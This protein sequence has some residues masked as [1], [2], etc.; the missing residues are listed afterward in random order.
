ML[1]NIEHRVCFMDIAEKFG[2]RSTAHLLL[3]CIFRHEIRTP[4]E[5]NYFGALANLEDLKELVCVQ[6][7]YVNRNENM[8]IIDHSSVI[9][10]AIIFK[11]IMSIQV[12]T[13]V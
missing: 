7:F 4:G 8:C 5:S 13:P 3:L 2:K 9:G 12:S 11:K 10:K 1:M 6:C